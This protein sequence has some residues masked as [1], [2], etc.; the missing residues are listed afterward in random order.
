MSGP[1]V[2]VVDYEMG[3]I[4]SVLN[5]L[6]SLG[7][8]ARVSRDVADIARA[9]R[10]VLPGVGAFGDGMRKLRA[11]GVVD[12]LSEAVLSRGKPIIGLCLGMQLFAERG[13]EHGVEAGLGWV[14]GEVVALESPPGAPPIRLPHIGWN[15][16][17]PVG[18][19]LLLRGIDDPLFYFVHGYHFVPSMPNVVRGIATHGTDFVAV[20][21]SGNIFGT[22]FHP[23]KSHDGGRRVLKNFLDLA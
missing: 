4:R 12:R 8:A 15:D 10:L 13:L 2:I 21:E 6:E 1:V 9:D 11:A 14:R 19:S 18:D 17:R 20:I 22:Q 5:A 16:V 23:E 7:A 3:N